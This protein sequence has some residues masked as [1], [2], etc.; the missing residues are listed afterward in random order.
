MGLGGGT[1][2]TQNKVLPGSYIN[3]VSAA[4]SSAQL[5]DRGYV[6]MALELDWG[7]DG[8]VFTVTA[9]DFQMESQRIFG[10]TYS[11]EKMKGLRD[12]FKNAKTLYAYR[13]NSGAKAANEFA[14]A[15]HSGVRGNDLKIVISTNVDEPTKFNIKTLL[16]QKEVDI[17]TVAAAGELKDN[18]Y[19]TFKTDSTLAANAGVALSGGTNKATV[20][21]AEYQDFLNKIESF[22]FNIL[23]CPNASE[24]TNGLLA[25]FTKRMRE[26]NGVKFQAVICQ[27]WANN[28]GVINLV[29]NT[30]DNG[31]PASSLLYWLAGAEAGCPVNKSN[32]N[33]KYDGEFAVQVT[34]T[35]AYLIKALKKGEL[36]FHKVGNDIRVLEDINSLTTFTED[37]SADFASNQTIRVLDQIGND[38][39]A[40]F[41]DKYLGNIP[42]DNAGRISLWNDIVKHHQE[43]ESIRAIENFDADSVTVD[44]G[45]TKKSVV[46]NDLVTPVNAMGQLYMTIVVQ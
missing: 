27:M 8:E 39:A 15:K 3:F 5:S 37:K 17:Q 7:P 13:L 9:E 20:T 41:N 21:A 1:F 40:I 4:R 36:M 18:A 12:L 10:Y 45:D 35:Q 38:I 23:A 6:A 30:T 29:S 11:H 34:H 22:N 28:E 46:V 44:K 33:K 25:S 32:T 19:V 16:D 2:T 31:W 14:E 42:N 26:D 24:Q 43:L